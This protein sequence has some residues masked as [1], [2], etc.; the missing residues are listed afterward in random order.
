MIID[1]GEQRKNPEYGRKEDGTMADNSKSG[2]I[3]KIRN[4]SAQKVQAPN[5]TA[6]AKKGVIKKTGKDLRSK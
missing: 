5:Q 6:P 4:E 3:G 1:A 2:Y